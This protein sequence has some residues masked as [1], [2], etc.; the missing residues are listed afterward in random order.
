MNLQSSRAKTL[1]SQVSFPTPHSST[2][3]VDGKV[4]ARRLK[5]M[6]EDG[7]KMMGDMSTYWCI[8][9]T[10]G[11]SISTSRLQWTSMGR[12]IVTTGAHIPTLEKGRKAVK[13]HSSNK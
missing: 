7:F 5:T 11:P 10:I 12:F 3:G 1:M 8:L 2:R 6:N 4:R 13:V 9:P